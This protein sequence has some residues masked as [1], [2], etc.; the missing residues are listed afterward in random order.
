MTTRD[1][2]SRRTVLASLGTGGLLAVAGCAGGGD[3]SGEEAATA[4]ATST[5]TAT[6]TPS[7][8]PTSGEDTSTAG[9]TTPAVSLPAPTLGPEDAEVTV[10]AY[11]NFLCSHCAHYNLDGFPK[12]RSEYVEPGKIRYEHHDFPFGDVAWY[13]AIAAR[14]AQATVGQDAFWTYAKKLYEKRTDTSMELYRSLAN[15]VGADPDVVEEHV[16]N[17]KWKPVVAVD[18]KRG[19]ELGVSGTPTFFVNGSKVEFQGGSWY[20]SVSVAIDVALE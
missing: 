8:T 17:L 14:S 10:A 20:E 16:R 7:A 9:T 1:R 2:V 15:E 12:I 19:E 6:T 5:R 13:S 18:R 3:G 11:E 4:T